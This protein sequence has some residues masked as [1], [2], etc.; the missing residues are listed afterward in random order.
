MRKTVPEE[1]L[2][3]IPG[4]VPEKVRE[5]VAGQVHE[6]VLEKVPEQVQKQARLHTGGLGQRRDFLSGASCCWGLYLRLCH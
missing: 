2:E 5:K 6:E 1:V 4:E 3:K